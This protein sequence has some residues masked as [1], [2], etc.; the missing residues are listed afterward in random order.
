MNITAFWDAPCSL[1]EVYWRFKCIYCL[2]HQGDEFVIYFNETARRCILES[3]QF[4]TRRRE[5]KISHSTKYFI[6]ITAFFVFD[7]IHHLFVLFL[8]NLQTLQITTFRRLGL[9]SY[10]RKSGGG[11][12]IVVKIVMLYLHCFRTHWKPSVNSPYSNCVGIG[13]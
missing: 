8:T 13:Q 9:P 4:Y 1:V 10:A 3:G 6:L 2:H 11:G 7:F 12:G 5:N